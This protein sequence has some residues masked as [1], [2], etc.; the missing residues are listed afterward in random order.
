MIGKKV[1]MQT[2]SDEL[3][4]A[5]ILQLPFVWTEDGRCRFDASMTVTQIKAVEGVFAAHVGL[6]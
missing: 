2:I 3:R 6:P 5:G 1:N 4:T